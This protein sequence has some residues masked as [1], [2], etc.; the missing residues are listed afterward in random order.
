MRNLI[1]AAVIVATPV[2]ASADAASSFAAGK[3]QQAITEGRAENTPAS[4]VL[5]GRATLAI[6]GYQARDKDAAKAAI[7]AAEKDFDRAI[8]KAPNSLDARTNKAIATGYRAKIDKSPGEGKDAR[9]QMQAVLAKDPYFA[10]ANAAL[11]AWHGGAVA[12]IGS[13]LASTL[14]GANRKDMDRFLTLAMTREPREI[15]HPVT[16]AFTLLDIGEDSLPKATALLRTAVALPVQDAYDG[17]N[18]KAAVQVL[19]LLEAKDVK[20]ARALVKKL[21]PFNNVG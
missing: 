4:L 7:D 19:A 20:G 1:L 10:L 15:V 5:A 11:G 12:T 8:A 13:F 14:L 3:W 2:A 16:Y 21:E 6:A 17:Q 18:H 9:N